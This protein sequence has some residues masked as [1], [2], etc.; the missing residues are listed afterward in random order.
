MR[1]L[2]G[3][4]LL[5]GAS[6][7]PR[8]HGF[9]KVS[10]DQLRHGSMVLALIAPVKAAGLGGEERLSES[11]SWVCSAIKKFSRIS[12]LFAVFPTP[13]SEI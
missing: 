10:D 9:F 4:A 7:Q 11:Y 1:L 12:L 5:G 2:D 6:P 3:D 13:F 8:H